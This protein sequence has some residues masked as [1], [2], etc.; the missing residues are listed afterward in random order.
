MSDRLQ[1]IKDYLSYT[2][3]TWL[4]TGCAGFIGSNLLEALL[5][6]NQKVIGVDNFSTGFR[7]NIEEVLSSVNT[8]LKKNFI[9]HEGDIRSLETCQK[10]VVGVDYVLHQAALGS[11]PRSIL[12]PE[13]TNEV[14][15]TGFLNMLLAAKE[16]NVKSFIYASS[17]SVYGDSPILPK[18]EAHI[19]NP[20]SPYAVSKY[21]N[22]LYA[23]AFSCCYDIKTIGLRYFNV[24]GA[25]QNANGSYAAVIP[26]WV[27]NL[28]QQ[29]PIYINGDGKTTRDFCYVENVIQANLLAA[30]VTNPIAFEKNY[31]IA[32]G[33]QTSLTDLFIL[34]KTILK[35]DDSK[36]EVN[37]RDYRAGD[38]RH[39][40]AD[41]CQAQEYLNYNPK[42]SVRDGLKLAMPW[43][44]NHFNNL[45]S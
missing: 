16:A 33:E 13:L 43:Y 20:L 22:E 3:H 27:A 25:R 45:N 11:V 34:I 2:Q 1:D 35:I 5:K 31:N 18:S 14:N 38:I 7:E 29:K 10:V 6:L 26:L 9:F 19:G 17:S 24:F 21:T 4:I 36:A 8:D 30:L 32:V 39:S 42:F 15:V 44:I 37:Y 40:L 12:T 23:K 41:I 28:I